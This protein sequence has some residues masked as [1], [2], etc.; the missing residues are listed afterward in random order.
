MGIAA[1][2]LDGDGH[3]ELFVTNFSSESNTLYSPRRRGVFRDRSARSGLVAPGLHRLGWGTGMQDVD[4][5]GDMDL[6]VLNGHVYPEADHAGTD[7]SY[8]QGDQVLLQGA[9]GSL[10]AARVVWCGQ[11]NRRI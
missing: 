9:G 1:G 5:D 2:D 6:W 7:T 10:L 8:A 3:Q 4:L 11:A